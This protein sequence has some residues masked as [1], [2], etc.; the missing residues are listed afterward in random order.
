M[1][2]DAAHRAPEPILDPDLPICDPHHHLWHWPHP[3]PFGAQRYLADE[4]LA[5]GGSCHAVESTVFVVANA[6]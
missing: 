3:V 5:D 2:T 6:F 4:F 1:P